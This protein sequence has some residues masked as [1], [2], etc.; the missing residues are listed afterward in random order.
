MLIKILVIGDVANNAEMLKKYSKK[1]KMYIIQFPNKI[2]SEV[3]LQE[4][5][6]YFESSNILKSVKKIE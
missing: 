5:E 4:G 2:Y 1:T 6:E 3:L